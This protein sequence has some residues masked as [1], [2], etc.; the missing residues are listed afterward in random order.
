MTLAS[1]REDRIIVNREANRAEQERLFGDRSVFPVESPLISGF[2]RPGKGTFTDS[3][4]PTTAQTSTATPKL[5]LDDGIA[6]DPTYK[7]VWVFPTPVL[8]VRTVVLP[9]L[10]TRN[11]NCG[12]GTSQGATATLTLTL[13]LITQS[14][15]I[16][17]VTHDSLALLSSTSHK[18]FSDTM[19]ATDV[20]PDTGNPDD[21]ADNIDEF[22][23]VPG[24]D[25]IFHSEGLTTGVFYGMFV[26]MSSG[27]GGIPYKFTAKFQNPVA[28][29][30]NAKNPIVILT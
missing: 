25:M 7:P 23:N 22:D 13:K 8:S 2:L 6:T 19:T 21:E 5:Q 17:T 26:D 1:R 15:D 11:Y 20:R 18:A 30:D 28:A 4:N 10:E 9:I 24:G 27:S 29:G 12:R 3:D 16:E 14:F